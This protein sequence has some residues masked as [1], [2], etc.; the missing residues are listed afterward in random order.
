ME[1]DPPA[2][3]PNRIRVHPCSSTVMVCL[4][5]KSGL[6][7]NVPMTFHWRTAVRQLKLRDCFPCS[8]KI[9]NR[10]SKALMYIALINKIEAPCFQKKW[11]FPSINSSTHG[12]C[13]LLCHTVVRSCP[14]EQQHH[15]NLAAKWPQES[16]CI[17]V[18]YMYPPPITP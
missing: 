15:F 7:V 9:G 3:S 14:D 17:L 2:Q 4:D 5:R 10:E 13:M 12:F 18:S 1:W 6:A 11:Q 8:S 16:W